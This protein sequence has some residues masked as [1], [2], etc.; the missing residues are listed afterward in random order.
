MNR[1][2]KFNKDKGQYLMMRML[3]VAELFIFYNALV[4]RLPFQIE[5]NWIFHRTMSSC[6][7]EFTTM[8]QVDKQGQ[9]AVHDD[10]EGDGV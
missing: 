5:S 8:D 9:G 1:V 6:I 4:H 7:E 10:G 3:M 2:D